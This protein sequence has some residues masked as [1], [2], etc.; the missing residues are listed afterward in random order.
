M[1]DALLDLVRNERDLQ[2]LELL[3]QDSNK[4]SIKVTALIRLEKYLEALTL[5][6]DSDVLQKSY[7][8]LKLNRLDEALHVLQNSNGLIQK[9]LMAQVLNKLE[10]REALDVYKELEEDSDVEESIKKEI[11]ANAVGVMASLGLDGDVLG[12]L[13]GFDNFEQAYNYATLLIGR[14]EFEEAER[15]LG[16][17]ENILSK[18]NINSGEMMEDLE[19]IKLVKLQ[20]SVILQNKG[21]MDKAREIL[22]TMYS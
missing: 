7:C 1:D 22:E 17:A 5:V 2:I 16:I 20:K 8:L 13:E 14:R 10:K 3:K 18:A 15:V 21:F 12:W 9:L 19:L 11:R 4:K 6:E